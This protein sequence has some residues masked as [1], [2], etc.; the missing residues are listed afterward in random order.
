MR[1]LGLFAALTEETSGTRGG[2]PYLLTFWYARHLKALMRPAFTRSRLTGFLFWNGHNST[3]LRI[4]SS[5]TTCKNH[6]QFYSITGSKSN[7]MQVKQTCHLSRAV[8]HTNN[9]APS[10]VTGNIFTAHIKMAK[11]AACAV[12]TAKLP[13][14]SKAAR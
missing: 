3:S 7:Y 12:G 10:S 4:F 14:A 6:A 9:T 2:R 13:A 5:L 8:S 11:T 1:R